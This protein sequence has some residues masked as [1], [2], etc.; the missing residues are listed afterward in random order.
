MKEINHLSE[1]KEFFN[2][3][4]VFIQGAMC[5]PR[6]LVQQLVEM[7]VELP[8]V[9]EVLHLH[10]HGEPIYAHQDLIEHFKITNLFVGGNMRSY[11]NQ[12]NVDYIPCFL[13]EIS[14]F[15]RSGIR[16]VDIAFIQTSEVDQ[17]GYVNIGTSVDVT[18]AA[19]ES[20]DIVVAQINKNIPKVF[21]D[22]AIKAD[23]IDYAIRHDAP[24][25]AC[26]PGHITD[27]EDKIGLNCAHL[28][29]DGA[30]LQLGIGAIPDAVCKNLHSHK[31]LGLHTEMFSDEAMKLIQSGV[32]T[33]EHKKVHPGR[34]VS[35]FVMGTSEVIDFVNNNPS[36]HLYDAEYVNNPSV[37]KRNPKTTAINSAVEI[38]LSG[39]VCADS[40]GSCIISGVGGQMDFIRGAS[41]SEG[42]LPIIAISS[43]TRKGR[44]KIVPKLTPGAGVVTTRAHVHY[45]VTEWGVTNLY[46]K[47]LRERA[48]ALIEISHPDH[49][50]HLER[51]FFN[52]GTKY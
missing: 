23:F 24:L 27:I 50:E 48:R 25:L 15:F 52:N 46:G 6:A 34:S 37:I 38:D 29:P 10:T 2:N 11:I 3:K 16:K 32:I 20:A 7:K 47:T 43:Q 5:T 39:Q 40:I 35:S 31:G 41:I 9:V 4:S 42:G 33:N 36:V 45:V 14:R 51:E 18:R 44:S 30:T 49:R 1:I 8:G 21:G 17:F 12:E 26:A 28:I 13:S 22:A 19:I